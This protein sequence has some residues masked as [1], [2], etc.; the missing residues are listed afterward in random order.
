[1]SRH[2]LLCTI[3]A[4]LLVGVS[5]TYAADCIISFDAN[6][7]PKP[8]TAPETKSPITIPPPTPQKTSSEKKYDEKVIERMAEEWIKAEEK[9][10][11][12]TIEK[13]AKE[14][15]EADERTRLTGLK[16]IVSIYG[17]TDSD[18]FTSDDNLPTSDDMKTWMEL[19][20]RRNKIPLIT[21]ED[22]KA[23]TP[24]TREAQLKEPCAFIKLHVSAIKG[25]RIS[26][27]YTVDL[28]IEEGGVIKRTGKTHP[29]VIWSRSVYGYAGSDV[30]KNAI[31][32]AVNGFL[33]EL[34]N[35]FL[36]ANP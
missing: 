10:D 22:L 15:T 35:A 23:F 24:P 3:A 8:L 27:I 31:K 6:C 20:M 29:V 30:V 18:L 7:F 36:A 17:I 28:E 4:V 21:L 26:Y 5:L 34:A 16:C 1:M 19:S 12:K 2:K 11:K 25:K 13:I 33:D 32:D 14:L 9:G